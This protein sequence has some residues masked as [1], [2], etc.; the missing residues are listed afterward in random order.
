MGNLLRQKIFR[1]CSSRPCLNERAESRWNST[2][3]PPDLFGWDKLV[4]VADGKLYLDGE[5]IC[6]VNEQPKQ[7]AVVNSKLIV[8]PDKLQI[9]LTNNEI[10]SMDSEFYHDPSPLFTSNSI[11]ISS[12]PMVEREYQMTGYRVSS[13]DD[14]RRGSTISAMTPGS[15]FGTHRA[16][17]PVTG[18]HL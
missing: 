2:A 6:A 13:R 8:W 4:V 17:G 16:A 15:F 7:F 1:R 5:A 18:R 3:R 10:L 11:Q 12:L 9:D 14:P